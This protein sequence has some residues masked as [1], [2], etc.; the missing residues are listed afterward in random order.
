[1]PLIVAGYNTYTWEH[2]RILYDICD[3]SGHTIKR[4][5]A[6][7]GE[8]VLYGQPDLLCIVDW[9]NMSVKLLNPATGVAYVLPKEFSEEHAAYHQYIYKYS[10]TATFGKVASTGVYKVIRAIFIPDGGHVQQL[11]EVCTLDGNKQAGW[12]AKKSPPYQIEMD[13]WD[14]VVINGI[15]YFFLTYDVDED[16]RPI[17]S[18]NLETEEWSPS[19]PGPL[20][21]LM[22]AA[23]ENIDSL[24][25]LT[26]GALGGSLV[27]ACH[28]ATSKHS[29]V[30]LWFLVDFE[31]GLWVKQYS[32]ELSF[33]HPA[34]W[35][36][37]FSVLND[38]RMVFVI[39]TING[40][41]LL[42][43]Y[44]PETKT[45]ED[46]M[47]M[48]YGVALGL[49]TGSALSLTNNVPVITEVSILFSM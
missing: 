10:F 5:Y 44:N 7:R 30:N 13:R 36:H 19:I 16:K 28:P 33:E 49:Y 4:V 38:G 17:G 39:D 40:G 20:S 26:I 31:K 9:A 47:E 22:E 45:S 11:Y 3:L 27:I 34:Y 6:K 1:M 32:I 37:P 15:I 42:S 35:I 8:W 21:S 48:G 2:N 12:R 23:A 14:N 29:S 18:F 46:V 43:I 41:G 25:Q 24:F